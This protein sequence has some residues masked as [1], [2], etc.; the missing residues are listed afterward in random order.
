VL[1]ATLGKEEYRTSFLDI[2]GEVWDP[3]GGKCH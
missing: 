3:S 1:V 2:N